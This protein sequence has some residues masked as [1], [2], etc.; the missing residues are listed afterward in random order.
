MDGSSKALERHNLSISVNNTSIFVE[1]G[2]NYQ[3]EIVCKTSQ[4][5]SF[6]SVSMEIFDVGW[7]RSIDSS[8][9]FFCHLQ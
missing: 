9:H 7:P 8:F 4:F 6:D 1:R 5:L 3:T 2:M